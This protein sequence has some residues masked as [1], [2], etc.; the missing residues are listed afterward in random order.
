MVVADD[1][2]DALRSGVSD[3]FVGLDAAVEGDDQGESAVRGEIDALVGDAVAFVVAVGDVEI[4]LR[5]VTAEERI[6]QG[7]GRRP[8]DV[9]VAVDEDLLLRGD[10][11]A[12]PLH[13]YVHVLHQVLEAGAEEGTRLLERLDTAGHEQVRENPVDAQ[14]RGQPADLFGIRRCFHDPFAL[15]RHNTQRY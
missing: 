11:P 14:F 6:H 15:F 2:V 9:I 12:D 4:D 10:G 8:V 5:S 7:D 3:L 13:G 1:H